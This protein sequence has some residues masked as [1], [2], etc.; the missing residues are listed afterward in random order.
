M[1]ASARNLYFLSVS[2]W[3]IFVWP[4]D[5]HITTMGE[6]YCMGSVI[7]YDLFVNKVLHHSTKLFKNIN[8]LG[9]FLN[10]FSWIN[11][12][13]SKGLCH[14]TPRRTS[15][16]SSK[17]IYIQ[18]CAFFF[19]RRILVIGLWVGEFSLDWSL[20][21]RNSPLILLYPS[22]NLCAVSF[23]PCRKKTTAHIALPPPLLSFMYPPL[24]FFP[25]HSFLSF[26]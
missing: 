23:K 1:R 16:C 18:R 15:N 10:P 3:I 13:A 14:Q 26:F 21:Y 8:G 20:R 19:L 24:H 12:L 22:L 6:S 9:R 7:M 4:P 2:Q 5:P 17:L 25:L 11:E